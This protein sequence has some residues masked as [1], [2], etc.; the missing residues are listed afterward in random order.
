MRNV[1]RVLTVA[2]WTASTAGPVGW[3]HRVNVVPLEQPET[4]IVSALRAAARFGPYFTWQSFDGA[5]GWRPLRDLLDADVVAD[6]VAVGR[7]TLARIAKLAPDAIAERVAA[8][9]VFLGLASRLISP[10]LAAN[11]ARG[12]LPLPDLEGLRWRPVES[13]PMPIAWHGLAAASADADPAKV[14]QMLTRTMTQTVIEP[15]LEAFGSRFRVSRQVLWGNVASA[16]A[17]AA[18]MIADAEPSHA[19]RSAAIVHH[20]LA[21]PPLLGTA[22]LTHPDP[23]RARWFLVRRNC[24][25]YYRI[26]GGGMCG[27]CVLTPEV[28]RRQQWQATLTR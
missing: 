14:A 3:P 7:R 13:G 19:Q 24:C 25:L 17:G 20:M 22:V 23:D 11:A 9:I 6:R 21:I 4:D 12:V 18:G 15:I 8:S 10:L 28:V 26:P 2:R 16:L 5:A 27:D 1:R